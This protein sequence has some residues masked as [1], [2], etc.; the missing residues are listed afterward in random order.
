ML[1]LAVSWCCYASHP[2]PE[3]S[4][5]LVEPERHLLSQLPR[6]SLPPTHSA[7][8]TRDKM[9]LRV[10]SRFDCLNLGWWGL[11]T[12]L[13]ADFG[14]GFGGKLRRHGLRQLPAIACMASKREG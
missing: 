12:H 4:I 2:L 14:T 8:V 5:G 6:V 7:T 13:I 11:V 10:A 1:P 9:R 3:F